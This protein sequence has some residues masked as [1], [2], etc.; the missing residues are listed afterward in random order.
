M[1]AEEEVNK[2]EWHD[3]INM[4]YGCLADDPIIRHPQ[5]EYEERETIE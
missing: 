4:T 2:L 3:F 5:G 1:L